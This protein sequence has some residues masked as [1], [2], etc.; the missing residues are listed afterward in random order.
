MISVVIP[1]YNSES[2]IK[3]SIDSVLEQTRVDL[4]EEILIVNDG[5]TDDTV[6]L[7]E[8]LYSA[9]NRVRVISKENG[10]VST[11]RNAG[12]KE[13]KG[14]WIALL[15]SDDVW[16]PKKLEKQW[17]EIEKRPE[18]AFI[19]CNRN[20]ENLH[21][22]TKVSENLYALNLHQLLIKMW[23]HTSTALIRKEVFQKVGYFNEQMRYAED[24]E[25]WNRIAI[26]YPLYYIAESLEIAGGNKVSFG[27]SGLSANLKGMYQGNVHNLRWMKKQGN[28]S[29]VY[30]LL[31]RLYYLLKYWR[32]IFITRRRKHENNCRISK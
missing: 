12:I 8:Q 4:V 30:F 20:Q 11:A 15:D 18:I 32:R 31:L 2:T 5:S 10:G 3:D 7:I 1:A 26:H 9:V 23:P 13:A 6:G 17:N 28:I 29:L 24:G 22:G 16:L 27:E 14:E 25:L 19:G 21:Y